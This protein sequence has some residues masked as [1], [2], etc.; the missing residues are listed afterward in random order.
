MLAAYRDFFLTTYNFGIPDIRIKET[1]KCWLTYPKIFVA[2]G[3]GTEHIC[4]FVRKLEWTDAVQ[5]D[6][7]NLPKR[8]L[9]NFN[10][11]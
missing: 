5:K 7:I 3:Q 1:K 4:T 8:F 11:I 10:G 2:K 9:Y 6:G